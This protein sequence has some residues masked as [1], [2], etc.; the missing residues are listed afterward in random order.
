LYQ[1]AGTQW[2]EGDA[3]G[4]RRVRVSER[5]RRAKKNTYYITRTIKPRV[6]AYCSIIIE[7]IIYVCAR[8]GRWYLRYVCVCVCVYVRYSQPRPTGFSFRLLQCLRAPACMCISVGA[9]SG[10]ERERRTDGDFHA[11]Y[12]RASKTDRGS[13]TQVR[14]V[15]DI[16]RACVRV[17]LAMHVMNGVSYP[18]PPLSVHLM[19]I[20]II[21]INGGRPYITRYKMRVC[22]CV[23]HLRQPRGMP[24]DAYT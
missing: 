8:V 13:C 9:Q 1:N 24:Q 11:F 4:D 22:V 18:P 6:Y 2:R 15:W 7:Y 20:I 3:G 5:D 12:S 23:E 14:E 16:A 10:R 19:T 17:R 21:I